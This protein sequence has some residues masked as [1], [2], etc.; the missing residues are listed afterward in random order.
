MQVHTWGKSLRLLSC[1]PTY[2]SSKLQRFLFVSWNVMMRKVFDSKLHNLSRAIQFSWAQL[3]KPDLFSSFWS[4]LFQCLLLQVIRG[5]L[6]VV[7]QSRVVASMFQCF[8][9][10]ILRFSW[11]TCG[12]SIAVHCWGGWSR[13]WEIHLSG[14]SRGPTRKV[15]FVA[16]FW[17]KMVAGNVPS[18]VPKVISRYF[19]C[20]DLKI[21]VRYEFAR[22]LANFWSKPHFCTA[23]QVLDAGTVR[24]HSS[25]PEVSLLLGWKDFLD[26]ELLGTFEGNWAGCVHFW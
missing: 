7:F 25:N 11:Q 6:K 17:P 16:G 5:S 15:F 13:H 2:D 4:Y 22:W 18:N 14:S 26:W 12:L 19:R 1:K 23:R 9:I 24:L 3:C 21:R 8:I 10:F 20:W